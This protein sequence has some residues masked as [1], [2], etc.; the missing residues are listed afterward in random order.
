MSIMYKSLNRY[1]QLLGEQN[2]YIKRWVCICLLK[3]LS[4]CFTK[5]LYHFIFPPTFSPEMNPSKGLSVNTSGFGWGKGTWIQYFQLNL[6]VSS[7]ALHLNFYCASLILNSEMLGFN[8][9]RKQVTSWGNWRKEESL[10]CKRHRLLYVV[11][12][13]LSLS[14]DTKHL[15]YLKFFMVVNGA[16]QVLQWWRTHLPMQET[17]EMRVWS[18]G[19]KNPLEKEIATHSS[20]VTWEIP[21]VEEPAG[22]SPWGCKRVRLSHWMYIYGCKRWTRLFL[23][24]IVFHFHLGYNYFYKVSYH[25]NHNLTVVKFKKKHIAPCRTLE[26]SKVKAGLILS[27]SALLC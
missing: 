23:I 6:P 15:Q 12:G 14:R 13:K 8:F 1:M 25:F 21:W 2:G 5:C 16:S 7:M 9:S 11:P 22:Y 17:Q 24:G 26:R 27:Q 20:I 18:L 10:G 19:Q 3:K 4:N